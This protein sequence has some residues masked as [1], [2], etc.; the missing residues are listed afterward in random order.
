MISSRATRKAKVLVIDDD[1]IVLEVTRE[2]LTQAGYEVLVREE[3]LGTTQVVRD[4]QPDVVLLDVLMPA[5]NG[6]RI[7]G[8]LKSN[9]RTR[10]V[11]VILHS[12]KSDAELQALLEETAAAGAISK[13]KSDSEFLEAFERLLRK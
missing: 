1:P 13:G 5:L 12:S 9:E 2:R 7:V 3:A 8:L 11:T 10:H 4:E 6:E